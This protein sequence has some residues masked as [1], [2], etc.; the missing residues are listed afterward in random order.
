MQDGY[1]AERVRW[2]GFDGGVIVPA[3]TRRAAA[4]VAQQQK[5]AM[6]L[7]QLQEGF[8][9]QQRR[10]EDVIRTTPA[11]TLDSAGHLLQAAG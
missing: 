4:A 5:A 7:Q 6:A 8:V 1:G 9:A 2:I 10:H 3:L 11:E